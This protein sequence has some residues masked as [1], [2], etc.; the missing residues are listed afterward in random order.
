M[1]I[2]QKQGVSITTIS[3]IGV[4][5]G[6]INTMF[7]FPNVLGA[8][9]HGLIMLMLSIGTVFSQ[10]AHLGIPNTII[11]FFPFL[12]DHKKYVYR[13]A[14]QVPL[15]SMLLLTLLFYVCG[16]FIFESYSLKNSLFSEY[17][18]LLLPLI[19]SLVFFEVLLSISRSELKTVFPA[20]LREFVL[21]VVTTVLLVFVFIGWIDFGAFTCLWLASYALNVLLLAIYLIYKNLFNFSFGLPLFLNKE[22]SNKM[23]KYGFITLL[24]S[25]AAILVN[26]IDVLMLGY[27]LDLENISFYTV[28][29]FMATL[30]HIPA[31]SILQI[32]KPLLAKAW[33]NNDIDEIEKLYRKTAINQML[34][35]VLLFIGIWLNLNDLLSFMSKDYQGIQMVF[36][37]LGLAK[38]VDVSAGSNGAIIATSKKYRFDL[39]INIILIVTTVLSNI[40]FIPKYGIEGA[41]IATAVALFIHNSIKTALLYKMFGI[42]PFSRSTIQLLIIGLASYFIV[43][44]IAFEIISSDVFRILLRSFTITVLFVSLTLFFG[45]SEDVNNQVRKIIGR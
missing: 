36:F 44:L 31:R 10:F 13:L 9:K 28:A 42:Q 27:Y 40:I 15:I 16:S 4:I 17:E 18:G 45:I 3:F 22:I 1:G 33:A 41:A 34:I 6:A 29:F 8:E 7:L 2:V 38:L 43:N 14:L 30:I 32:V 23:M 37:Y 11:R 35:G 26:R 24:T 5:I 39:Y 20:I 12:K 21:R 19:G 25:S